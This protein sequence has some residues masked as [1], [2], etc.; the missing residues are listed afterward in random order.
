ML[1]KTITY[2][3]FD[4]QTITEDLFF[5]ISKNEVLQMELQT[6]GGYSAKIREMFNKKDTPTI[7]KNMEE[8]V[9]NAYGIKSADGRTF[10]KNDKIREEFKSSAAYQEL[11]FGLLTDAD[12]AVAFIKGIMPVEIKDTDI[13]DAKAELGVTE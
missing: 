13:A 5:N 7:M 6:P 9:L 3:N 11:M 12:A 1:K 10:L 2:E 8:I 4:G